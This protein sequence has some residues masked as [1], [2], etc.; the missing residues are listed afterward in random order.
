[1]VKNK[2]RYKREFMIHT[3]YLKL[4][5]ASKKRRIRI[6][7]PLDYDKTLN[8]PVLYMHDGQNVFFDSESF[9]KHSWRVIQAINNETDI[10]KLIV[11]AIDNAEEKRL[12][13]YGPWPNTR[14]V[15]ENL[16]STGGM[17]DS[18]AEWFVNQLMP[19]INSHY[20]SST[21]REDT[22][23][24]GSSMGGII[25]AYIAAKYPDVFGSL[26]VFSLASWFSE[27]EFLSFM[28]Q[29]PLNQ[30][31]RVYIQ[32][33]SNEGDSID[34]KQ[35]N[36][37]ISQAYIDANIRYYEMLIQTGHN[38]TNIKFRIMAGETHHELYWAKHFG[39]YLKF[40]FDYLKK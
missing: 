26:G 34:G 36:R 18:Y 7:L 11:V 16:E 38:L 40:S 27:E 2:L 21:A 24:A 39:D 5:Y 1:M 3:H 31:T 12:D 35:S 37:E 33:G 25:T 6:L 20:A 14:E 8:Y 29:H 32:V 10:P 4:P 22:L 9:V 23:L 15:E 17:G 30:K 13:E 19:F 28:A